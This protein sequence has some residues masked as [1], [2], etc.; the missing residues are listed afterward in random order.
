MARMSRNSASGFPSDVDQSGVM[1][2]AHRV[3]LLRLVGGDGVVRE[4]PI[5]LRLQAV[6]PS[7][8]R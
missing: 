8:R 4:R 7:I 1:S 2:A 6:Q 5:T 3:R